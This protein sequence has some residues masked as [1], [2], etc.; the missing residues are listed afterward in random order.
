MLIWHGF[1]EM[2]KQQHVIILKGI[3]R[4]ATRIEYRAHVFENSTTTGQYNRTEN[5]VKFINNMIKICHG[6]FLMGMSKNT[7]LSCCDWLFISSCNTIPF[8]CNGTDR[9]CLF[10][11]FVF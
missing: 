3:P 10:Y 11:C 2:F 6:D 9:L 4:F 1:W 8:F 7:R 5:L